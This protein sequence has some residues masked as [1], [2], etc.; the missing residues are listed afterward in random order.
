MIATLIMF[1][2]GKEVG[3]VDG[4]QPTVKSVLAAVTQPFQS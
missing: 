2:N 3:R 4:S 1:L